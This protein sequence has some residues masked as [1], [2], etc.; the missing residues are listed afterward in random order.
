[1]FHRFNDENNISTGQG[2]ISQKNLDEFINQKGKKNFVNNND[3]ECLKRNIPLPRNKILFTFDDGLASQ[4]YAAKPLLDSY[5]IKAF[6]FIYTKIF[7]GMYDENEIL[8][9][10]IVRNFENFD[11]FYKNFE[12]LINPSLLNWE[13][14]EFKN[15]CIGL[16]AKFAFYTLSDKK[17]RFLRNKI[18]NKKELKELIVNFLKSK[19]QEFNNIGSKVWISKE[20]LKEI[21][22]DGHQIGLHSHN[23]PYEMKD[24]SYEKQFK[25]YSKNFEIL[26]KITGHSPYSVAYPLGSYNQDSIN[27]MKKLKIKLGFS[28]SSTIVDKNKNSEEIFLVLPRIDSSFI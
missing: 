24:L 5:G 2:S 20:N 14:I 22:N 11:T 4:F 10:F 1:M 28:S 15:Y 17:Y 21:S 27:V 7:E 25:E 19:N 26:K 9:Y 23:H 13:S 12:T 6:W 16:D 8:N 18:L 3:I